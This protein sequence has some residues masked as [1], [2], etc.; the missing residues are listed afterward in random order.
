MDDAMRVCKC[1]RIADRLEF[2]EAITERSTVGGVLVETTAA[3]VFHRV[4]NT[5]VGERA[6]VV[7]GNDSGMLEPRDDLSFTNHPVTQIVSDLRC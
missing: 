7:D 6:H 5:T 4:V 1:D 3:H 2:A